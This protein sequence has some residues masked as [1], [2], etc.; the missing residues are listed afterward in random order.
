MSGVK[1]RE[2]V[3]M[4]AMHGQTQALRACRVANGNRKAVVDH[5]HVMAAH[6]PM[7]MRAVMDRG[8]AALADGALL[9]FRDIVRTAGAHRACHPEN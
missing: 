6:D 3:D 4:L 2:L 5:L 8:I 9:T 7:L 1:K